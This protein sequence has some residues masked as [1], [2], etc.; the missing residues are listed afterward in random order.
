MANQFQVTATS[1]NLR[2]AP[3]TTGA[4]VAVLPRGA[5]VTAG[6]DPA[7]AN[8]WLGVT[9]DAGSGFVAAKFLAPVTDAPAA[10]AVDPEKRSQDTS[11]LHPV[12]RAAAARVLQ[13]L[14]A[15]SIPLR[16][17]EAFRTPE[18]QDYLYAQGRTRPGAVVTNAPPWSS[19]HQYGLASDFVLYQDGQWSWDGDPAWWRRLHEI[20][21]ANGLM[22]LNFETPH[23]QLAGLSIQA[24]R[25]GH[26]PDGGV[27]AAP[28][29]IAMATSDA[30]RR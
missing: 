1:L 3:D 14:A 7:D 23:L 5:V 17:F 27:T 12:F 30:D 29:A 15:E 8:G 21:Q 18:R 9:A 24:L 11:L 22:P 2:D 13:Q 16:I 4:V 20:G 26:Y 10:G 25:A 19:F 28:R 6:P